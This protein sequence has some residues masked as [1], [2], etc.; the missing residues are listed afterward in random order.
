MNKDIEDLKAAGWFLLFMG[1]SM[2]ALAARLNENNL[3]TDCLEQ[4]SDR[5][6]VATGDASEAG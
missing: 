3:E 5:N 6:D 4:V 2:K 1:L